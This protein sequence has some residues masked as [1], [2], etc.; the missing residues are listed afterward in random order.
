M[1]HLI[2]DCSENILQLKSPEEIVQAVHD[3]A[4]ATGLFAPENI[5]ARI[6]P[7]KDY[8][9]ADTQND[10]IHVFGHIMEGRT[11]EQKHNLS[12]QIVRKLKSMFPSVPV[13]SMNVQEFEK[14]TYNNL[15]TV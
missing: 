10:F 4:K 1:P 15:K 12:Q 13:I 5:K 11:T 2:I 9:V 8:I 14:A 7:Y 6:T 3:V